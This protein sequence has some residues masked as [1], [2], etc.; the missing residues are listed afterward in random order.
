MNAA[1]RWR[2]LIPALW[3]GGLITVATLATPA[4][5]ATLGQVEAGRVVARVLS[6]EAHASLALGVLVLL[7]E[8][9]E[10][11]RAAARGSGSQFSTGMALALGAVFCTILGYFAL[12]PLMPAARAGQGAFSFA[13]LHLASAACYALKTLMVAALAWRAAAPVGAGARPPS[14]SG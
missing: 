9:R 4:P 1:D 12:Q 3:A 5:F 13:Q 11:R 8:R 6:H 14:S 10:A 2:V 7:L